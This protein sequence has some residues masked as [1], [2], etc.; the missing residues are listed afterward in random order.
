MGD[1]NVGY[2]VMVVKPDRKS[3]ERPV[4]DGRIILG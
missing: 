3:L 4:L 2:N 1:I